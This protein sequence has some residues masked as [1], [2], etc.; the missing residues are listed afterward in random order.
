VTL[1]TSPEF[2]PFGFAGGLYDADTGLVHF[3]AREYDASIGRWISKDP[4]RFDGGQGNL[5][6]YAADDPVN[7]S[8]ASGLL[9]YD[10]ACKIAS[11]CEEECARRTWQPLG[12]ISCLAG[13]VVGGLVW[14]KRQPYGE[15]SPGF[16]PHEAE[17]ARRAERVYSWCIEDGFDPATCAGA[18]AVAYQRC[19]S[20][21]GGW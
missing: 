13:C 6:A 20:S 1:D 9:S 14:E 18:S 21:G 3:R 7:R 11:T 17:C 2:Q 10:D 16:N 12:Y 8:D 4:I 5:Y 15:K 19:I